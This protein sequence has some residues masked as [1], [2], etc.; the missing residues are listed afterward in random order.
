MLFGGSGRHDG[1]VW[2]RGS[3]AGL[4]NS[5][6][7]ESTVLH[8]RLWQSST[9]YLTV[10]TMLLRVGVFVQNCCWGE[11]L[12]HRNNRQVINSA[13]WTESKRLPLL[14]CA[15]TE[16]H[17]MI[18]MSTEVALATAMHILITRSSYMTFT[19]SIQHRSHTS[20]ITFTRPILRA[21]LSPAP[22]N[23]QS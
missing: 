23:T 8:L 17:L 4:H 10:E 13:I 22:Y 5:L 6:R 15:T 19:R 20:Y 14:C 3:P 16:P 21:R 2:T 12:E 7:F 9:R 11:A 18:C 1:D